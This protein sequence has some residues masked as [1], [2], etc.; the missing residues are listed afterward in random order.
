MRELH[1]FSGDGGGIL[2]GILC[3]DVPLCAVEINPGCRRTLLQRQRDGILPW[4]PIWGDI[5]TFDAKPWRGIAQVVSGGFPCTDI[6]SARTNS[7]IN[8]YQRGIDGE[9]SGLW[10]E[11]ERVIAEAQ[12]EFV[13]IENSQNL[14]TRGLVRILKSLNRMGY[15]AR[16]GVLGCRNF[17]ADHF[18]A[19]MFIIAHSNAPQ[20]KGG[21]VSGR[22]YQEYAN[23]CGSDWWKNQPGLERVANG[24]P[25]QMER[26]AAIGNRQ[27][28]AVVR[29]AWDTLKP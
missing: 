2:G 20:F 16:W 7:K 1:L 10:F 19:R 28:P 4:F 27:V 22:A 15:D 9:S 8:G 24:M 5:K 11:M 21:C 6:S 12:P 14:R 26:L 17:G 25:R 23:A 29:L 3:G 13:R 18:R